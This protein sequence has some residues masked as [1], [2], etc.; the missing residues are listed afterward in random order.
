VFE[1][2]NEH[3]GSA[4]TSVRHGSDYR[5]HTTVLNDMRLQD[6]IWK[7]RGTGRLCLQPRWTS[8]LLIAGRVVRRSKSYDFTFFNTLSFRLSQVLVTISEIVAILDKQL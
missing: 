6:L 8:Q 1:Q 5:G 2:A 3:G 4:F 7:V